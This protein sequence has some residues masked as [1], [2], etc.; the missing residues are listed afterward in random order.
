MIVTILV[1]CLLGALAAL[2]VQ[3]LIIR[4]LELQVKNAQTWIDPVGWE[5][6]E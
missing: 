4:E 3:Q 5:K 2:W 1:I 6:S